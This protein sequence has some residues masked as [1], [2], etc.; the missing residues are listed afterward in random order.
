[1]AE[2]TP[3]FKPGQEITRTA[4][5]AVTGGQ[6]VVVSGSDT[7]ALSSTAT[8]A[9]LGVARFD[10]ASGDK[11]TV[12]SGGVH[13]LTAS[14]AVAAGARVVPA[15]A[16]AVADLGAGTDYS[17]VVGI[18]LAAATGGKVRVKLAR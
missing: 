12:L 4:S 7:V 8:H 10:V 18:A 17:Q 15:A 14:G 11:V 9:W 3:I 6:L 5:A 13:E 1:M 16:G 2:Y